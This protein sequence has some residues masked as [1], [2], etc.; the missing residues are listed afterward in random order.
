MQKPDDILGFAGEVRIDQ[1]KIIKRDGTS[2][3]IAPQVIALSIHEDLFSPFMSGNLIIKDSLDLVNY[4]PF[5]G[6]EVVNI[7]VSTPTLEKGN[8][9]STFYIY[10][11]T[12]R[13]ILGDKS[14]VYQLHFISVEAIIDMNKKVSKVYT[15]SPSEIIKKIV[16]DPIDGLQSTKNLVT[17]PTSRDIQFISNFWSPIESISYATSLGINKSKSPNYIFFENRDGFYF[18]TLDKLYTGDTYQ[19]FTYDKYTRDKLPDGGDAKNVNEDFR[20][21]DTISIPVGFDYVDRISSGMFSSKVVSYDLTRK[22]Y[23]VRNYSIFENFTEQNHLNKYSV[24]SANT[25]FKSN[26][27][28]INYP[29]QNANFSG[30]GDLTNYKNIQER[31]SLQKVSEANRLEITVPGRC[32]YTVGMKVAVTLNKVQPTSENDDSNEGVDKMF[33]GFYLIAAIN[34]YINRERHECVME[35]IKDSLQMDLDKGK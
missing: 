21:I 13:E 10:K 14:V 2:Q 1:I 3:D 27:L 12:D 11:M 26:S 35:L 17:E 34:H 4:F 24:A 16:E 28:L 29:R 6:D 30:M 25:I 20:R 31:I 9:D 8:I 19:S 7:K 22:V 32:D 15:G 5:S 18:I 33:S 23:N